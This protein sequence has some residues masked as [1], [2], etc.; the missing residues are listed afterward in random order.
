MNSEYK[1]ISLSRSLT[2]RQNSLF[3][4]FKK[5]YKIDFLYSNNKKTFIKFIDL[6]FQLVN[7]KLHNSKKLNFLV[8]NNNIFITLLIK[9]VFPRTYLIKDIGYFALDIKELSLN[10]KII[11]MI[12]DLIS[13]LI[14]DLILFESD[15]QIKRFKK[16][17]LFRLFKKIYDFLRHLWQSNNRKNI[18]EKSI[19]NQY[20]YFNS[21]IN[22]N[23]IENSYLLFR[24]KFNS[25]SGIDKLTKYFIEFSN[26][27][28]FELPLFILGNGPLY[29]SLI[30]ELRENKNNIILVKKY[31]SKEN[32]SFN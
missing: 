29:E 9:L 32:L 13:I 22:I 26:K 24:G 5:K 8:G 14:S 6:F 12:S 31:L 18:D 10:R 2:P 25:E 17:K 27:N 21:K 23:I 1:F 7:L 16:Y 3:I 30:K 4:H 19:T 15:A 20:K 28:N 11:Y